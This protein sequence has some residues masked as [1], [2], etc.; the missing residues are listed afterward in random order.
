M[1]PLTCLYNLHSHHNQQYYD[2][3]Q[4]NSFNLLLAYIYCQILIIPLTIVI[5]ATKV[6]TVADSRSPG[7][8]GKHE[9]NKQSSSIPPP[10]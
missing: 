1:G 7:R 8:H 4:C 10:F 3:R 5:L 2:L 6:F 9:N